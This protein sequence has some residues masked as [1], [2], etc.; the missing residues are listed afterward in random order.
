MRCQ[1][2]AAETLSSQSMPVSQ[3]GQSHMRLDDG[4]VRVM[5]RLVPFVLSNSERSYSLGKLAEVAGVKRT[6]L[7]QLLTAHL[8]KSPRLIMMPLRLQKAAQLLTTTDL[9]VE[10]VARKCRFVSANFFI[11]SFF[12]YYRQSPEDY[13]KSSAR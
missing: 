9:S 13:R 4:F 10:E 8:D 6:E 12:H 3:E 5:L 11:A 1:S 7:Y 2:L